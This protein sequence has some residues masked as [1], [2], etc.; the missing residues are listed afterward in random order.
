MELQGRI[1]L[2]TPIQEY[3]ANGFR[4]REL[5]IVTEEQYPQT[6]SL[7]FT[8]GNCELLNGYQPG[9]VV[10]VTFDVRGREWT[11]PQGETKYFNSLVAWRIVNVEAQAQASV[12]AS[13]QATPPPPPPAQTP[14]G[15]TTFTAQPAVAPSGNDLEDDGLPF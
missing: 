4:K 3:G 11:N 10:K 14:Q 15:G 2:I 8:Q 9:Q 5:I 12:Q 6:I 7:E 13:T 1:K